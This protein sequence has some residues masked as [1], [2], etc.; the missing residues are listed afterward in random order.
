MP[1]KPKDQDYFVSTKVP[2]NHLDLV[3]V[4]TDHSFH[5]A[6]TNLQFTKDA[7]QLIQAH[8]LNVPQT[9]LRFA[10]PEDRVDV[11]NLAATAFSQD[12]FHKDQYISNQQAD[13]LK[14]AW[15]DNFF[16]GKRGNW[17]VVS[18]VNDAV[19]GFLQLLG[20][21]RSPL[22]IDLVAVARQFHGLGLA[23]SMISFA[24]E[25][26]KH[27]GKVI[28]GTQLANTS[29]LRLYEGMGFHLTHSDH[30]LHAHGP[31]ILEF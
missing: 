31:D 25:N 17:M 9:T 7:E 18:L 29:S 1:P 26:C 22:T 20:G 30:V 28:V 8:P 10:K 16:N 2:V 14:H 5:M 12:R 6:D 21:D 24:A 11:T 19:A 15:T 23:R 27:N 4:L 13:R 3:A